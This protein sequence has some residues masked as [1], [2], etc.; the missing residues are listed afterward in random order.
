MFYFQSTIHGAQIVQLHLTK[1]AS[2]SLNNLTFENVKLEQKWLCQYHITTEEMS[3]SKLKM[4]FFQAIKVCL[5]WITNKI[6][7]QD[8]EATSSTTLNTEINKWTSNYTFLTLLCTLPVSVEPLKANC[9]DSKRLYVLP[10][11]VALA[12]TKVREDLSG[13]FLT[14]GIK[15]GHIISV[16]ED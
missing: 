8:W 1:Y 7:A 2:G 9:V 5:I 6:R 15:P 11:G 4:Y 14:V 12:W 10:V 3:L 16:I 13:E